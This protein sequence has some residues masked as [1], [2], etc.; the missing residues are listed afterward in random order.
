MLVRRCTVSFQAAQRNETGNDADE[1]FSLSRRRLAREHGGK[2]E[3][4]ASYAMLIRKRTCVDVVH[5]EAER[6]E[7][8]RVGRGGH[9]EVQHGE[10]ERLA[11]CTPA[12][13]DKPTE[14]GD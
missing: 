3:T 2:Q 5:L 7:R 1:A 12:R 10:A 11:A 4:V 14:L 8:C 6:V 9:V 13:Q